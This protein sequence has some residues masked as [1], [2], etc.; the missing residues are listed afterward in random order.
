LRAYCLKHLG[1]GPHRYLRLRQMQHIRHALRGAD[2]SAMRI[3]DVVHRYGFGGQGRFAAAY[4]EQ[5]GELPSDTK[6][7]AMR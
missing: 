2:A 4:R 3:A 6:R 7:R 1:M 5:Y